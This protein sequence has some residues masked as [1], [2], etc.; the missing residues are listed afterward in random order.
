[1]AGLQLGEGA[2]L[3]LLADLVIHERKKNI[4]E[5]E[6][7]EKLILTYGLT[8]IEAAQLMEKK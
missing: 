7:E 4:P 6:I 3:E 5:E 1:M 8:R 2:K